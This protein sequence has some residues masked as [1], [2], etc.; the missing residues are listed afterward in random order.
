LT[1]QHTNQKTNKVP[2]FWAAPDLAKAGYPVFPISPG[3]K[4]PSVEGGF[5]A[6]T[7]DL[8]QIA[9]WIEEGRGDHDIAIA[10][11]TLSGVVVVEADN[12]EM[13][14]WMEEKYG[15]PTVK[16]R[17]G[18]HWWFAHPRDGRVVSHNISEDLDRKGDGG[19]ALVPP[20]RGKS[21]TSTMP[22]KGALPRL[23]EALRGSKRSRSSERRESTYRLRIP[24]LGTYALSPA[25]SVTNTS[26]TFAA[27]Y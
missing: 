13:Y 5:Y 26:S 20:S 1:E 12:D 24:S 4:K 11:G 14:A 19:Y 18:G 21:W 8:S 10:A 23:P 3:T 6:A 22:D 15:P 9:E 7:T 27:S 25:G 17:R 16:S 2:T